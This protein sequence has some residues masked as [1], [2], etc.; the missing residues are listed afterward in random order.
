MNNKIIFFLFF[1]FCNIVISAKIV[2]MKETTFKLERKNNNYIQVVWSFFITDNDFIY[3]LD[4]KAG[5]MKVYN[6]NGKFLKN[7]GRKGFGPGEYE[8]LLASAYKKNNFYIYDSRKKNIFLYRVYNNN[9]K[10]LKTRKFYNDIVDMKILNKKLLLTGN[11]VKI[12]NRFEKP[13]YYTSC[14]YDF[15]SEKYNYLLTL[16]F[17]NGFKPGDLYKNNIAEKI[18]ALPMGGY[19]DSSDKYIFYV[20]K[21]KLKIFRINY[22]TKKTI[23]FRTKTKNY[24][25]PVANKEMLNALRIR[26]DRK[27]KLL[28]QKMSFI[29]NVFVVNNKYVIV[30]YTN[31]KKKNDNT[32]IY[33]QFYDV[34][35][36]F[37]KEKLLLNAKSFYSEGIIAYYQKMKKKLYILDT[38]TTE[39]FDQVFRI[40]KFKI[41][42]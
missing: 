35:G 42:L 36:K 22:K 24:I 9:I 30:L 6:N 32:D 15:N 25:E 31:Y 21:S 12:R 38:E 10:L 7:I 20:K 1:A 3:I 34:N 39:D 13:T 33:I 27:Y 37:I 28:L 2:L 40:H 26:N 23:I 5:N 11:F 4:F 18:F 17:C 14:I 16:G 29:K 41:E 19:I 8:H